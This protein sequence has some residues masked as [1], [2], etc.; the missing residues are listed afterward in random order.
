MTQDTKKINPETAHT[1]ENIRDIEAL[2]QEQAAA[3]AE[4]TVEI[5][6]HTVYLV[7]LCGYF[8][9]SALVYADGMHIYHANDYAL[10][11]QGKSRDDLRAWY[12][13]SL[14]SKL[15]TDAE[16]SAPTVSA[17]EIKR[18]R[19]YLR[20]YYGMR[21]PYISC[22]Q[23][24]HNDAEEEAFEK[25]VSGFTLNPICYGYYSDAEF[26]KKCISLYKVIEAAAKE[27]ADNFD[28]WKEAFLSEM[29]NHEYAINWQADY[30]V[31]SCFADVDSVK[32]Y[33]N[34]EKLFDAA[35]FSAAQ[36]LAYAAAK[37]EYYK[38]HADF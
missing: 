7:D 1:I 4:E 3:M 6:G 37:A 27:N 18:R 21:R 8:G 5:K 28:Y 33:E 10:H 9:Y 22:F 17:E 31:I 25:K 29:I 15:F 32:D 30:D 14:T 13:S 36:R 23:I 26:V 11:H 34:R 2:T 20:N 24:F 16:L 38:K 19:Y 12:I 35:R